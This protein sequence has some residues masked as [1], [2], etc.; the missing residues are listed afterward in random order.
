MIPIRD[1]IP[2]DRIPF[3]NYSIIVLNLIFFLFELTLPQ[4]QLK[5]FFDYFGILPIRY[6]NPDIAGHF[7][8]TEQIIPFFSSMFLH[9]GWLHLI[10][11]MWILYIFG[12]NVEDYL[13]H[14][15]Y[16]IFYLAGGLFSGIF[17]LFLNFH[18]HLPTIGAS[19]AIAAI[20]GAY[21][22][23]YPYARVLVL[24]PIF[25]FI[26][27]IEVPA[28]FFLGFWF[29]IQFLSGTASHSA[30]GGVAWWAHVGGFIAGTAFIYIIRYFK[31]IRNWDIY[32]I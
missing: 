25:V 26:Q 28:F 4:T 5:S 11:N 20:M 18:S 12:D 16:L 10:G 2:S 27:F 7:T 22:M 3:I 15:V 31:R 1:N 9:G 21:F 19:G 14:F 23:L 6:S 29:I 13:G 8:I 32:D 17:N 24:I 30:Y